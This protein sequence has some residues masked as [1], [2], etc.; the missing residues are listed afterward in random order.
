VLDEADQL[1]D[2]AAQ[3]AQA[4]MR[5]T[6]IDA[7]AA[8]LTSKQRDVLRRRLRPTRTQLLLTSLPKPASEMQLVC[9]SATAGRT[10]RQQLQGLLGAASIDKAAELVASGPRNVKNAAVRQRAL[11]PAAISHRYMLLPPRSTAD[12]GAATATATAAAATAAA[13]DDDANADADADANA[14][15]D[16]DADEGAAVEALWRAMQQLRPAP[17]LVFVEKRFGARRTADALRAR[18]LRRVTA[19]PLPPATATADGAATGAA[20][21]GAAAT[22]AAATGVAA[23]GATATGA[24]ATGATATGAAATGAAADGTVA[25]GTAAA[26]AGWEEAEVYV[27]SERWGRGLDLRLGYVFILSPPASTASYVHMAGRT[28]RQGAEGTCITLLE[29]RQAPRLV[30]FAGALGVPFR[31][32]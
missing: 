23:T 12:A 8:P 18:G 11:M 27:G 16:A 30:A 25:G 32:L 1:L 6:Q 24:T 9:L 7:Q 20:A 4:T 3:A 22:G 19:L 14:T 28:G 17:A 2:S 26:A 15:T 31:P 13:D 10:L 29:H 21:T 5:R